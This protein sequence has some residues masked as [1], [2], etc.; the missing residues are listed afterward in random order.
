MGVVGL[1][2]GNGVRFSER[3]L[4]A[5][6]V[7]GKILRMPE[8]PWWL[9]D[10]FICYLALVLMR[11]IG[12]LVWEMDMCPF[13]QLYVTSCFLAAVG[14]YPLSHP[15][16]SVQLAKRQDH[17]FIVKMRALSCLVRLVV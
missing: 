11:G 8:T 2:L 7:P 6:V 1:S 14:L 13:G 17:L 12:R 16:S 3:S 15:G 10:S 9:R 5:L 4:D